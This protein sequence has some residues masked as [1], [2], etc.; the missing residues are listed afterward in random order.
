MGRQSYRLA[1]VVTLAVG[2]TLAAIGMISCSDSPTAPPNKVEKSLKIAFLSDRDGNAE[3]YV[4]DVDGT[5]Q[6]RLTY[7]NWE[8]LGEATD[9]PAWTPDGSKIAFASGQTGNWE[10]YIMTADGATVTRLTNNAA[11]DLAPQCSMSQY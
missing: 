10:I 1:I 3:I 2:A 11:M 7:S 6:T 9:F 4:M 8:P 5:N